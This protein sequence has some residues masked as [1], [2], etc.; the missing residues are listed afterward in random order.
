MEEEREEGSVGRGLQDPPPGSLEM[1]QPSACLRALDS[2]PAHPGELAGVR[3]APL[4]PALPRSRRSPRAARPSEAAGRA[5]AHRAAGRPRSGAQQARGCSMPLLPLLTATA[6][7]RLTSAGSAET[8]LST[9]RIA[10]GRG[11]LLRPWGRQSWEE[12]EGSPRAASVHPLPGTGG[13]TSTRP[14]PRRMPAPA[15]TRLLRFAE[16]RAVSAPSK[17]GFPNRARGR[18]PPR[19]PR[20]QLAAQSK[21]VIVLNL[22]PETL[23]T[24]NITHGD[25]QN[26]YSPS[27]LPR[28]PHSKPGSLLTL[29]AGGN[30]P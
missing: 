14:A 5:L 20:V 4:K 29:Q 18:A 10:A 21:A 19:S 17:T 1:P 27:P 25:F 7:L 16:T 6:A 24:F 12:W 23:L 3:G 11:A 13:G 2:A 15:W 28:A 26:C 9:E 22:E 30:F 8:P